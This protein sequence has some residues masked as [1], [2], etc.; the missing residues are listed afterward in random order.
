MTRALDALDLLLFV[1]ADRP[2]RFARAFASGADAAV[3]DLE[4]A[5]APEAKAAARATLRDARGEVAASACPVLLRVN[6][7]GEPGHA[8][9][10]ALAR[11]LR[12]AGVMLPKAEGPEA[13]AR[14]AGASG[15]PVLALVETARG[16]ARARDTAAAAGRLALGAIDLAAD[17]GCA[18]TPEA[19]LLA[20]LELV[21]ASR[22][23]GLAGPIDGVTAALRD[24]ALAEADARR[25]ASLGFRGKLL[26]H[27]SQ[28]APARAGFAPSEAELAWADRVL[29][30]GGSGA[31]AV[32]GAMVDRPVRLRA[33]AI[34]RRAEAGKVR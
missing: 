15:H 6:A 23:G 30:A 21:L 20:R 17:L 19:L 28:V 22:L 32:D 10:L 11:D 26:I 24:P 8:E 3:I 7:E 4:D 1:P 34:R 12:L 9:D 31:A 33:E 27:P 14:V 18:E 16:V 25:A 5:V 29:G 2:E 13:V